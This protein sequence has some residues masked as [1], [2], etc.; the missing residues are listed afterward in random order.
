[1]GTKPKFDVANERAI[2]VALLRDGSAR[3]KLGGLIRP[4]MFQGAQHRE[5]LKAVARCAADEEL[6]EHIILHRA[7]RSVGGVHYL[8]ALFET[9]PPENL[10]AHAN[11][12][13]RDWAR[14]RGNEAARDLVGLLRDR[15]VPFDR[16]VASA[17]ALVSALR[18]PE[19][20]W[21]SGERLIDEYLEVLR[22]RVA[23]ELAF[24]STGFKTLDRVLEEG[25]APGLVTVVFGR[26][27]TGKTTFVVDTV[28]RLLRAK[29]GKPRIL[30]LPLEP[31][32]IRFM[33]MLLSSVT[34][35]PATML[36]RR[37]ADLDLDQVEDTGVKVRKLLSDGLLT[38]LPNP[39]VELDDW[40]N[41]AAMDKREEVI[42]A[43]SPDIVV[44]DLFLRT[45]SDTKPEAVGR[46]LFRE[47]QMVRKYGYHSIAVHHANRD[48]EDEDDKR[49]RLR[50]LK[51]SGA[52]EEVA[53]QVLGTYRERMYKPLVDDDV[54]EAQI[55]KQRYGRM[56][57]VFE[58]DFEPDIYRLSRPRLSEGGP[59]ESGPSMREDGGRV[60]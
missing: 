16:C 24:R 19:M 60:F 23:G 38:V 59:Q 41:E 22:K 26:P 44:T 17:T 53:D 11:D 56:N 43:L 31:G 40:S 4:E 8:R 36:R 27:G 34:K 55:L 20:V 7:K 39:F 46:A 10:E 15:T 32:R 14:R 1:M 45:L 29:Q 12:L 58:A 57:D 9:E 33:D 48:V 52:W 54:W 37:A 35:L 42:A 3:V 50:H 5:I 47:Q 2:I 30:V 25:Y 28:R 18:E 49:P 21:H 51:G 6:D 13:V